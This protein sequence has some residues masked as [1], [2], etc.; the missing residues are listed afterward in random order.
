AIA[1]AQTKYT[2]SY[3]EAQTTVTDGLGN[4]TTYEYGT[5]HGVRLVTRRV[6]PCS[7]GGSGQRVEEWTYDGKG[8]LTAHTDGN[9]NVTN[10]EV[11]PATG[12]VLTKTDPPVPP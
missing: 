10:S 9:G 7:G 8:R 6:G 3:G 1:G 5:F 2:L 12:D 11:D 4:V